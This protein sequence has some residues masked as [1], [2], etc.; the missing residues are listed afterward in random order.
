MV[1]QDNVERTLRILQD[2]GY[3]MTSPRRAV[4]EATQRLDRAF[5]ADELLRELS[6]SR[7]DVG[8]ATVFRT[9]DVLV[10]NG[11]LDRIHRP[12]GCHSYVLSMSGDGHHHHLICSGCGTVVQ[13]E[14]CTVAPLLEELSKRTNFQISDHWLEV[15][16][17]CETCR[18]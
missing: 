3:R 14:D 4:I 1:I 2:S 10:Q 5:T 9:L 18:T 15:F 7:S 13:F 12:D 16:G 6:S 8:R 11:M 17:R